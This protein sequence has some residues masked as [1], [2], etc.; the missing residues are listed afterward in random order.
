M[1]RERIFTQPQRWADKSEESKR[2]MVL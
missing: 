2:I 1:D